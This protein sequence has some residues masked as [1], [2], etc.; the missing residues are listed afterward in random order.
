MKDDDALFTR[1]KAAA[2]DADWQLNAEDFGKSDVAGAGK[3][4]HKD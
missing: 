3:L 2:V 4:P 1:A